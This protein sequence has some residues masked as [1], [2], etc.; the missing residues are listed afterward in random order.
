MSEML[1]AVDCGG[2]GSRAR[3]VV[4]GVTRRFEGAAT[5]SGYLEPTLIPQVMREILAPVEAAVGAPASV[6][7]RIGAAGFVDS[8][9]AEYR[10]AA[11]AVLADGFGGA[12]REVSV[13]NDAIALLVGH[14]ADGVVVAG[15]G[16][17]V[18]VTSPVQGVE[19]VQRGGHD[20]VAADDGSGFWIGLDGVRRVARDVDDGVHSVLRDAFCRTYDTADPVRTFRELAVAGPTMKARIA[21]FAAAVC[22]AADRADPAAAAIVAAQAQALAGLVD[23]AAAAAGRSGRLRLV[24]CGGL[25][26]APTY[27]AAV[28]AHV[29]SDVEWTVVPDCLDALS[30]PDARWAADLG[31][32]S[33]LIVAD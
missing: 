18:L 25:L 27:R 1:V 14:D 17:N 10:R 4:D 6:V 19:P 21:R 8:V 24:G 5:L 30:A 15:T 12:V 32:R 22:A 29:A 2:T 3:V 9:R 33:A 28:D 20:W 11:L 16:S 23:R 31:H 26:T 7:V 13:A